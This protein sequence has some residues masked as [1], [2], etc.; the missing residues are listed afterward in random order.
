[1]KLWHN[2]EAICLS[3]LAVVCWQPQAMASPDT[4]PQAPE[5]Y[6]WR[7]VPELTDEFNGVHLDASKWVP[8]QP[9]WEGRPPSRFVTNNVALRDGLLELRSTALVADLSQVKD[10]EKDIWVGAACVASAK[11]IAN[12]GYYAARVKASRLPMTSSFWFQGKYS[13]IDVVEEI[14]ASLT[15]P[16]IGRQMLATTHF[17]AGGWDADKATSKKWTMPTGAADGFHVYGVWWKD[18][19]TI[20]FYHDGQKVAEIKPDGEFSEPMYLFFDTEVFK[21]EG[22]PTLEQLNDPNRNTMQVDWVRAWN[23][24]EAPK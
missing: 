10:R 20:W 24:E 19:D 6:R 12:Y 22:L 17:F 8:F 9:Y 5:G 2:R 18:K 13:E 7:A 15:H 4:P 21:W 3:W 23:L 16:E 1:M 11:P 14:G